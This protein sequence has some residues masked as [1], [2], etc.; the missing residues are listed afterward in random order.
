MKIKG[1]RVLI[2]DCEGT[3]PLDAGA[4]AK[5]S[6]GGD[7]PTVHTQLCRSQITEFQRAIAGEQP[8]LVA[9]TQEAPL[10]AELHEDS[11][12]KAEISFTNIR[13]R[14]GWSGEAKKATAKIAAL[15]AE[16]ALDIPPA[17][18]VSMQSDGA[19]LVYGRDETAI[20]AAKQ[21]AGRL[22]VTVLLTRPKDVLP[23]R[24]ID[25]PVFKGTITEARGHLGAIE[26]T[27]D[28]YAAMAPSSRGG[29]AFGAAK[30]GAVS[31]YDLLF[32][33]TGGA[34]LFPAPDKRDGYFNPDPGNPA[35]VQKAMFDIADMAG[36][37][38]KPLYIDYKADICVHSRSGQ[39]G[40]TRCLDACPTSAIE[41]DGDHVKIDPYVCAGCGSCASVC[42][43]GAAGYAL[44]AGDAAFQRLR[45]LLGT[46]REAAG[47]AP[48]LLVHDTRHGDDMIDM[49]ARHGRGLPARVLPFAL[50]EV[51]QV[52][53]DF[54]AAALAY[55]AVRVNLLVGPGNREHLP[56]LAGQV[57]LAEGAMTGLGYGAGRVAVIDA[58]DPDAVEA[59][60]YDAPAMAA[61]TPGTFLPMGGKRT[62]TILALGH[63]HDHAP[64]PTD[65]V[66][67]AQGAPFGMVVVDTK[68]CTLCL[69]CVGACPTGAL[70]DSP[71]QP[72]VRFQEDA[73]VQCGLCRAT[74][75]ESVITLEPRFNFTSAAH[76]AI[77]LNEEEPFSCVRCGKPFGTRPS[78]ERMVEKLAGHSMF[79]DDPQTLERIK[80]CEDC[81]IFDQFEVSHPMAAKPRP[82]PRT[83]EDDLREREQAKAREMHE[84]AQS[85]AAAPRDASDETK[86]KKST[87]K[88]SKKKSDPSTGGDA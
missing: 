27:I 18:S 39:A 86:P 29:L 42:P 87:K 38:E 30:N 58:E 44:P 49:I 16:A 50:N 25:V 7:A 43:T 51:T 6:G 47:E 70:L 74:C 72:M 15:L 64:A 20:E 81:R 52:G 62:V 48:V 34:P 10:F 54:F 40:C 88:R 37:F 69:A 2:C 33:L 63:L 73:C 28:D 23:P 1:K 79:V 5:A 36:T 35:L 41:P 19:T 14:A 26:V 80:M 76:D 24:V 21:L 83:T 77:V 67:L 53:F 56:A 31:K 11:N 60:L 22:D 78:I 59:L 57:E 55:G 13:E 32:D 66:P 3:M 75:P 71:D 82:L 9:C 68:G 65:I 46:Y 8:V 61:P 4:L 12:P 17:R 45:T 85:E 84:R